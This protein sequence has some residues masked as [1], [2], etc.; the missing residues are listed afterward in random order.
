MHVRHNSG[1]PEINSLYC[2]TIEIHGVGQ[3][4]TVSVTSN[5]AA[6]TQFTKE[7]LAN[8]EVRTTL[9]NKYKCLLIICAY[10]FT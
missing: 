9:N 4:S 2:D 7:Y 6:F 10:T 5:R 3:V 1:V 8:S